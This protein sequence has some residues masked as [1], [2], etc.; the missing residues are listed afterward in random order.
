MCA[1]CRA[2]YEDPGDRR[3]HAQPV[4]CAVCG[5]RVWLERDGIEQA[6]DPLDAAA[7]LL[8]EGRI[9]AIKGIGGFHLACDATNAEAIATLRAR[10]GRPAKPLA[11]MAPLGDLL[12]HAAPTAEELD[13]LARPRR[14]HRPSG[15]SGRAL[16]DLLAPGR[17]RS[18][19]CCPTRRSITSCSTVSRPR[20]S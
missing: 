12:R 17:Q 9:L 11:L 18:A 8:K 7:D 3:F 5:P 4:A 16:P 19:G 15:E 2:E 10:K 14:P 20:L 1:A 6:G 13:A